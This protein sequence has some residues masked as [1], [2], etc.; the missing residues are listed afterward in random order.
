VRDWIDARVID[1]SSGLFLHGPDATPKNRLLQLS[2]KKY[3]ALLQIMVNYT[4][5][6]STF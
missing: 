6:T 5:A 2:A 1:F 4:S 3:C